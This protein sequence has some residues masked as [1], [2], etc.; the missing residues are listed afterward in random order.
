MRVLI[1]VMALLCGIYAAHA[2]GLGE[3]N[4][5]GKLGSISKGAGIPTP[6]VNGALLLEDNSSFFL[7]ED[8]A[9]HLCLEGGC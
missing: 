7:L 9:S 4:R 1:A 5:F 8:G 2:F 6:P 3:G